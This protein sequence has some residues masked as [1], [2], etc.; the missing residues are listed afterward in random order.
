MDR[1][2]CEAAERVR[3]MERCFDAVQRAV[4]AG[5]QREEA[6]FVRNVRMLTQ[7]YESGLWQCDYEKDEQG[8]LP[9]GL[10]RGVL[11]QDAV[12]DLLEE[13]DRLRGKHAR[14]MTGLK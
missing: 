13:I 6:D 1:I 12:Y 2:D 14:R 8:L 3:R 7:Y 11:S 9:E 4:S 5:T 10:K